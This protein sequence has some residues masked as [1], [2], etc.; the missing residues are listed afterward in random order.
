MRR[1]AEHEAALWYSPH[2]REWCCYD[3]DG[4]L[5]ARDA[6]RET[7]IRMA[8]QAGKTVIEVDTEETQ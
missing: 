7:V 2:T 4:H 3:R 1:L 5:I 6:E 8:E